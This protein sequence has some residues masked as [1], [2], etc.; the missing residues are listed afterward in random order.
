MPAVLSEGVSGRGEVRRRVGGMADP[1][2][3]PSLRASHSNAE[4]EPREPVLKLA[5]GLT[6]LTDVL[7]GVRSE[8]V[9]D[10]L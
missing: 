6:A 9:W 5:P 2:P 3:P 10:R 1:S 4:P 7:C 8:D